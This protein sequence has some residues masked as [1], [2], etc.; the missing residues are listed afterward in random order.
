VRLRRSDVDYDPPAQPTL[1]DARQQQVSTPA[2]VR[3]D[4]VVALALGAAWLST[5]ALYVTY[6]WTALPGL[7]TLQ[8]ARFYVPALGPIALLAAWLVTRL[9]GRPALAGLIAGA[10]VAGLFGAGIWTFSDMT[11]FRLGGVHGVPGKPP[12]GSPNR[13]PPT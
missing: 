4:A 11:S 6:S 5:W 12:P 10:V 2:V 8:A 1:T 3:R 7:S 9:P 13:P